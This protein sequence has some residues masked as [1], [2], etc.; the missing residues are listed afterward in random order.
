M[1][2]SGAQ[3]AAVT[4]LE[5]E[6]GVSQRRAC[7]A[8]EISRATCRDVSRWGDGGALRERL[9]ALAEERPR[10]GYRRLCDLM[11]RE[12]LGANHKRIYRLYRLD[13]LAVR[14][15]KR[16]R[17]AGTRGTGTAAPTAPDQRWSMDSMCDQLV[18][19]GA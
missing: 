16:K 1:V 7:R 14:R 17:V 12:G 9:R 5:E 10:F 15:K 4:W 11:R 8:V 2:S 6:D 18:T 13:G 3:R 19:P